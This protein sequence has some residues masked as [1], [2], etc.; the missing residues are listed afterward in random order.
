MHKDKEKQKEQSRRR[1]QR[2]RERQKNVTPRNATVTNSNANVTRND[3][4]LPSGVESH[5]CPDCGVT[6]T[7]PGY[8]KLHTCRKEL[9]ANFGQ[10]DCQCRHC[11]NNRSSGSHKVINHGPYK[12]AGQ[13]SKNEVNRVSWPGDVDYKEREVVA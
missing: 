10:P 8:P 3:Q 4:A 9:P 11:K 2:Y 7:G 1:Q 12:P 6:I 5:T 13:L